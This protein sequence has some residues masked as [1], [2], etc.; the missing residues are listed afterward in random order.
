MGQTEGLPANNTPA[1]RQFLEKLSKITEEHLTNENFGVNELAHEMGMSHSG[2]HKR[3]KILTNK[4]ISRFIREKRLKKAH[5]LLLR[6]DQTVSEIAY[7]VGFG[8]V[9]YFD[10]CFRE[11]YGISPGE[12]KNKG[13]EIQEPEAEPADPIP[14]PEERKPRTINR[15]KIIQYTGGLIIIALTAY[16]GITVMGTRP[17][18]EKTIAI[19]PFTD[20]SPDVGKAYILHGLRSDL[21]S[22]LNAI[23][24]LTLVSNL[25]AGN[26]DARSKTPREIGNDLKANFLL[27]GTSQTIDGVCKVR[28]QLV[29]AATGKNLW[30]M[31]FEKDITVNNVFGFQEEVALAV[32]RDMGAIVKPAEKHK[33]QDTGQPKNLISYNYYLKAKALQTLYQDPFE[34]DPMQEVRVLTELSLKF[35]ST[36]VPAYTLMG[37]YY[38]GMSKSKRGAERSAYFDSAVMMANRAI[39][40]DK[41]CMEAYRMKTV[42][43]TQRGKFEA[44]HAASMEAL[45]Q[46]SRF[47]TIYHSL[48]YNAF[49]MHSNARSVENLLM[50]IKLNREPLIDKYFLLNLDGTLS[51]AGFPEVAE[52]Y[53][54]IKLN[55]DNDSIAYYTR[56]ENQYF[57][58]GR[59]ED[60]LEIRRS[61]LDIN[62][63]NPQKNGLYAM[64]YIQDRNFDQMNS[65][66]KLFLRD[67]KQADREIPYSGILGY[68]YLYKG[69]SATAYRHFEESE[70]IF[71]EEIH[72][73]IST[74]ANGGA[75][76]S[77]ACIYAIRGE[78]GKALERLRYFRRF[79]GCHI[80]VLERLKSS[81]MLDNIREMPE[82]K[83]LQAEYEGKFLREKEKVRKILVREGILN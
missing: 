26:Y 81:P 38:F 71:L 4:S 62:N 66:F 8:S 28:L 82:F 18:T 36:W 44:S 40:F 29:E 39:H 52:K 43:L 19:L 24:D 35:D 33:I 61:K 5:A 7:R 55:Q 59:Y 42:V 6:N 56:L 63:T 74:A 13:P 34:Y 25:A 49:H 50:A 80:W 46:D 54:L 17:E 70:K 79:E 1:D 3:L 73:G 47:A 72:E 10:T 23:K 67:M 78:S 31:P 32:A 22:S 20:E 12:V 27:T 30:S 41:Q 65:H 53:R 75:H 69:D 9:T 14:V 60:A 57:N 11:Y 77:L 21:I 64:Y 83:S 45:K 51:F 68:M 15:S 37:W 16:I 76:Y 48:G 2:L 58:Y